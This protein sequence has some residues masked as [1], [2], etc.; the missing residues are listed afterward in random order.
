MVTKHKFG[1]DTGDIHLFLTIYLI[2][3]SETKGKRAR[4][5]SRS[6]ACESNVWACE[7]VKKVLRRVTHAQGVC[8]GRSVIR[9]GAVASIILDRK[10]VK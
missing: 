6:E 3:H 7:R 4:Q 1:I 10:L 8:L 9:W 5:K 2:K